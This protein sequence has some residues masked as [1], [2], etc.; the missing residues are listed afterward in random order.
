MRLWG[1][2]WFDCGSLFQPQKETTWWHSS[3]IHAKVIPD[4]WYSHILVDPFAHLWTH[5][6]V[7]NSG[8]TLYTSPPSLQIVSWC[9]S[10]WHLDKANRSSGS[11]LIWQQIAHPPQDIQ[12]PPWWSWPSPASQWHVRS[13]PRFWWLGPCLDSVEHGTW[14]LKIVPSASWQQ[15]QWQSTSALINLYYTLLQFMSTQTTTICV[16][17][18][19]CMCVM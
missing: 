4:I 3:F 5:I 6:S 10:C 2:I 16:Y 9:Y 17:I 7:H 19:I 14:R 18:Y 13:L 1:L 15:L 8:C 11:Q 12:F